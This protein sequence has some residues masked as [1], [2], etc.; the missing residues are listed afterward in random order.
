MARS[1]IIRR[2]SEAKWRDILKLLCNF[3]PDASLERPKGLTAK[4]STER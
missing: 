4:K 2:I 3:A 1:R